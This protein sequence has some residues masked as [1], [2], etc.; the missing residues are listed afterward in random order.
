MKRT[1][2]SLIV[3]LIVVMFMPALLETAGANE[4]CVPKDA[5]TETI[6]HPAETHVEQ[7]WVVDV[8]A[9]T[10]EVFVGWQRYSYNG[11]WDSNEAPPFPDAKWQPNVQGDPHGVGVAGPYFRSNGNSGNV[12]WFYLEAVY[13][14]VVVEEQGHFEDVVVVDKAAWTE[15][16]KQPAKTC[17][18]DEEE[19]PVDEC[20]GENGEDLCDHDECEVEPC[21][22]E[23]DT[24]PPG[25]GGG[26]NDG[27]PPLY[28]GCEEWRPEYGP[29]PT[30][31]EGTV[32]DP[33]V[34]VQT[35]HQP[36]KS[37]KVTTH[38]SGKVTRE[39]RRYDLSQMKQEGM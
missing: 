10:T 12:D 30:E 8:P 36:G 14:T 5:W 2:T 4:P 23:P 6:E 37:V 38:A 35:S 7:K 9:S 24:D 21:D 15:T 32:A 18:P 29:L 34:N 31:C 22:D 3:T 1:I 39:V 11:S 25:T 17:P 13:E 33:V 19:P 26:T 20:I 27:E 28:G 16:I